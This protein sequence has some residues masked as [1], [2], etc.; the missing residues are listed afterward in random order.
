MDLV[1][2]MAS[3][4]HAQLPISR[5]PLFPM[6]VALWFAA[7]LGL[8]SLAIRAS[9]LERL[10]MALHVDLIL[11]SAAPPLG[12]TARLLLAL[13][14]TFGGGLA[15]W[16]LAKRLAQRVPAR[17]QRPIVA[18]APAAG[19]DDDGPDD[20]GEDLARLEAARE[21]LPRRR[22]ALTISD[23]LPPAIAFDHAPLPGAPINTLTPRVLNFGDLEPM[24][25]LDR[26]AE[27][28]PAPI[29]AEAPITDEDHVNAAPA[30]APERRA[31]PLPP[32]APALAPLPLATSAPLDG[33]AALRLRETPLAELGVV[34]LVERF[35]LALDARRARDAAIAGP[36]PPVAESLANGQPAA[37][38]AMPPALW[39]PERDAA[40]EPD[41][42]PEDVPE[43]EFSSLLD[44]KPSDRSSLPPVTE[45]HAVPA[46]PAA[47]NPGPGGSGQDLNGTPHG[48]I[49]PPSFGTA[50][51]PPFGTS[52]AATEHALR[53]ALAA[54]Q[55]MSGA[56]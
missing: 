29:S 43:E 7:L 35:A 53:D 9:L 33:S 30:P 22:R 2:K 51:P 45:L 11:P 40:P 31:A 50:P 16:L 5:H 37:P 52:P 13:A 12:F 25:P 23:D 4:S 47:G 38:F 56:A 28:L 15:G 54:L 17:R 46:T 1:S 3:R 27:V 42:A 18:T 24:P 34:E 10:V 32:L 36:V 19:L 20:D 26:P 39:P 55:R 49:P 44:M 8:G 14:L 6:V 21:A 41:A 48:R